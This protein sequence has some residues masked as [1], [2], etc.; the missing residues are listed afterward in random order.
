MKLTA[1][2]VLLGS[3]AGSLAAQEPGPRGINFYPVAREKELGRALAA[4][5]ERAL[6][7]VHEPRLEAYVT[8]VGAALAKYADPR[9]D[10]VF[11][12][13]EDRRPGARPSAPDLVPAVNGPLMPGDALR[14]QAAEPVAVPGGTIFVPMSLLAGAPNENAFAFQLAH[15][16]AHI[17]SRH[18]TRLAT[19][20]ELTQMAVEVQPA[21]QTYPYGDQVDMVSL[22]FLR[23]AEREADYRAVQWMAKAGYDPQTLPDSLA[24]QPK[25]PGPKA[26]AVRPLPA[27]RAKAIRHEIEKLQLAA[28]AAGSQSDAFAEAKALAAAMR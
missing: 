11:R 28:P 4:R 5:L 26:L 17:A 12:V 7:M 19:R 15:A 8:L 23:A 24:A 2:A 6:L 16:V 14:G 22:A 21:A 1:A 9:F 10:Y 13:Y 18:G 20:V 27:E 25:P 3:L